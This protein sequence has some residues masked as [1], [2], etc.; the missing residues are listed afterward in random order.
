[1]HNKKTIRG[2]IGIVIALCLAAIIAVWVIPYLQMTHYR[3]SEIVQNH[4][5]QLAE[6]YKE[7][8]GQV[9]S[10]ENICQDI[11]YLN[12]YMMYEGLLPSEISGTR[13]GRIVYSMPYTETETEY[14]DVYR[15]TFGTIHYFIQSEDGSVQNNVELKPWGTLYLDGVKL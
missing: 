8:S 5:A 4:A 11:S 7:K 3:D 14:V 12:R 2:L 10:K 13:E 6:V 1:M 15:D 9:I